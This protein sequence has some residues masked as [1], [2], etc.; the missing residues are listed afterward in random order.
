[1]LTGLRWLRD[2][3]IA[4]PIAGRSRWGDGERDLRAGYAA[5]LARERIAVD[6]DDPAALVILPRW[7]RAS[8]CPRSRSTAGEF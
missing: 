2:R 7:T 8:T 1:V 6:A 5:L 3:G 4:T